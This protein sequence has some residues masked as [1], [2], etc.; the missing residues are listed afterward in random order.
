MPDPDSQTFNVCSLQNLSRSLDMKKIKSYGK[1]NIFLFAKIKNFTI[2][3]GIL[4]QIKTKY[5]VLLKVPFIFRWNFNSY[6]LYYC[7]D[8]GFIF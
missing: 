6:V 4:F 5:N 2:T 1:T 8:V 7:V 3:F